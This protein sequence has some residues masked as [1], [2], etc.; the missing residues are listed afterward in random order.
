L[1]VTVSYLQIFSFF[2]FFKKKSLL[3]NIVNAHRPRKNQV[4]EAYNRL[5]AFGCFCFAPENQKS[6]NELQSGFYD[7]L[8][9]LEEAMSG[10]LMMAV[11]DQRGCIVVFDFGA[12][13]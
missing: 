9:M 5:I 13:K 7:G 8:S 3:L 11:A 2:F 10:T 1:T 12:N 6:G 4:K